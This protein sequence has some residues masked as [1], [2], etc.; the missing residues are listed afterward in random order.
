MKMREQSL[1]KKTEER[2]ERAIQAHFPDYDLVTTDS[3][4]HLA[5]GSQ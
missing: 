5:A 4:Q 2:S 1:K 3:W